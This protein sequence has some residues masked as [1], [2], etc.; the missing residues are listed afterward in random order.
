MW[1][2]DKV[3]YIN[4]KNCDDKFDATIK[5]GQVTHAI[6]PLAIVGV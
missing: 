2:N 6:L 5:E 1:W 3:S 4:C